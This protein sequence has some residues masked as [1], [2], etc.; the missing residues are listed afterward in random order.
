VSLSHHAPAFLD[1]EYPIL[2]DI[3]N[4]DDRDMDVVVDVLL[5]PTD[6]DHAGK[7]S[8]NIVP[9][10]QTLKRHFIVTSKPHRI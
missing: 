10:T 3:T 9:V 8:S 5:Q 1:E 7:Y 6:I 4:A 2:I